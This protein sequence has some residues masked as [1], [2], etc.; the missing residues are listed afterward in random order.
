MRPQPSD[1]A[2]APLTQPRHWRLLAS[3]AWRTRRVDIVVGGVAFLALVLGV[4]FAGSLRPPWWARSRPDP[5]EVMPLDLPTWLSNLQAILGGFTLLVAVFVWFA[6]LRDDWEE[7]LP[8]RMSV[9]FFHEGRPAI[10]CRHVWLAGP[11][12]LRAWGQQVGAQAVGERFLDFTPDIAARPTEVAVLPDGSACRHHAVRFH[13]T[14]RPAAVANP[15]LCRYQNL[16]ASDITA[17][18]VT[19]ASVAELSD[20][21]AWGETPA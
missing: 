13:L 18:T 3:Y 14:S 20:L 2:L 11:D 4:L 5:V 15:D 1:P 19:V 21:A 17:R 12:D 16:L 6:E 8:C 10:I 7:E 9:Y